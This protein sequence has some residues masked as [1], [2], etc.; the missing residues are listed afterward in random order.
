[1]SAQILYGKP[2]ADCA[3]QKLRSLLSQSSAKIVTVGFDNA[4]WQQYCKSLCITARD[5]GVQCENVILDR[6]ASADDVCAI[7][8][9]L[10]DD[11]TVNGI[12]VQQPLPDEYKSVLSCISPYKDLDCLN[13]ASVADMYYGRAGV[14][15]ATP[16]AVLELLRFYAIDLDGKNV[17]IVG[18]GNAVGKP[19]ALMALG[20]N[21]TVTVCHTHTKQL[22][23]ICRGA[24][25]LIT[26]C[27][28]PDLIT[29]DF[30]T[31][32]SIVVDV[33]LGFVNGQTHGDVADEVYGV[34]KAVTPVPGGVGPVTRI[35]LFENLLRAIGN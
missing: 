3:K 10:S 31:S 28:K 21:A 4:D 19:L 1:M 9:A 23:R 7:V 13:P 29:A 24:D 11:V 17:V 25:I 2:F 15:P 8:S 33:G 22:A 12:V 6:C 20:C 34:C 26:A 30:V 16:L 35:M 27:G 18:R 32:N 14:R 5:L